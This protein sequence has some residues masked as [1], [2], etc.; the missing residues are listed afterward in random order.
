M[1]AATI[2]AASS[3]VSNTSFLDETTEMSAVLNVPNDR[4]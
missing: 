3:A 2:G 1:R 4:G